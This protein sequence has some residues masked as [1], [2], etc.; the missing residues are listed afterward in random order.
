MTSLRC[1][2]GFRHKHYRVAGSQ[3]WKIGSDLTVLTLSGDIAQHSEN[4]RSKHATL[5][6]K[7]RR[8]QQHWSI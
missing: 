3:D 1:M 8:S 7:N 2:G 6:A 5:A 4:H